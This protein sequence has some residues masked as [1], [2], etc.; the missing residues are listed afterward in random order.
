MWQPCDK[1]RS[2]HWLLNQER[3]PHDW[4]SSD[5]Q[6]LSWVPGSALAVSSAQTRLSSQCRALRSFGPGMWATALSCTLSGFQ[7]TRSILVD[8]TNIL[9]C[10]PKLPLNPDEPCDLGGQKQHQISQNWEN[11]PPERS[12]K[13]NWCSFCPPN[14][15]LRPSI[16]M[17]RGHSI[18][19]TKAIQHLHLLLTP[20]QLPDGAM[21]DEWE[22][23]EIYS[24]KHYWPCRRLLRV[25]NRTVN[26][27]VVWALS[28]AKQIKR[29]QAPCVQLCIKTWF[30]MTELRK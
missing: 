30:A 13:S 17:R 25:P 21:N 6:S 12:K 18:F 10:Y 24:Y 15:G 22:Q 5:S 2:P 16:I 11:T 8:D 14:Q 7:S 29:K 4:T 26:V 19:K 23:Q 3:A 27:L 20:T 9:T 28:E 1:A